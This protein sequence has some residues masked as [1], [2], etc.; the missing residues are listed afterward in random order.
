[1]NLYTINSVIIK[2]AI[3]LIVIGLKNSYF[4]LIYLPLLLSDSLFLDSFVIGQFSKPITF[5]DV[6]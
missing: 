5:K 2:I 6:V 4:P 3:S 1:M